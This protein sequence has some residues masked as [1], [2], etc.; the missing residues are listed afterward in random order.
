[1]TNAIIKSETKISQVSLPGD[2][3]MDMGEHSTWYREQL[4]NKEKFGEQFENLSSK[5]EQVLQAATII[6]LE[7][8]RELVNELNKDFYSFLSG[9]F[10]GVKRLLKE[11]IFTVNEKESTSAINPEQPSAMNPEQ[12]SAG[13]KPNVIKNSGISE[14]IQNLLNFQNI[15][16]LI[17]AILLSWNGY[18]E[19]QDKTIQTTIGALKDQV[20]T[21]EKTKTDN[22]TKLNDAIERAD[23]YQDDLIKAKASVDNLT[24]EASRITETI[25]EKDEKI[26]RIEKQ[27]IEVR[28]QATKTAGDLVIEK[29][30]LLVEERNKYE[31][32]SSN[33]GDLQG[34]SARFEALSSSKS[35]R[36]LQLDGLLSE[37]KNNLEISDTNLQEETTKVI[38]L[39]KYKSAYRLA[40]LTVNQLED[41]I[42]DFGRVNESKLEDEIDNYKRRVK[43][44]VGSN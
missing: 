35:E 43:E 20:Q 7:R 25:K 24:A 31:E 12:P 4:K 18:R 39:Q 23:K 28:D 17:V 27:L 19:L 16:V 38:E 26:K 41:E 9:A 2:R 15:L 21:F 8:E 32:L 5:Q 1:M 33:F 6:S 14:K 22:K 37:S 10:N 11:P 44:I 34:K 13:N 40:N 29:D 42:D 30:R 36:I 3:A